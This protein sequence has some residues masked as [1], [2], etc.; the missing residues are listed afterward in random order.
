M[1]LG[2]IAL[3]VTVLDIKTQRKRPLSLNTIIIM[4][5]YIITHP[6]D[7]DHK[8]TQH[9]DTSKWQLAKQQSGKGHYDSQHNDIQ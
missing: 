1:T 3:S 7:K 2:I 5:L 8:E 4:T 6:N 9:N